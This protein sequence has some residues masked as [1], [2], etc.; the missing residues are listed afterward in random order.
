MTHQSKETQQFWNDTRISNYF[1]SKPAD[2]RLEKLLNEHVLTGTRALDLGCGGGRHSQFLVERGFRV[3][4][5]DVN[6]EMLRTTKAR[7]DALGKEIDIREGSIIDTTFDDT[8]FD[9]VVVTGVLHQARSADEYRVALTE[10]SRVL[11]PGGFVFLNIFTNAAW[12]PT[13]EVT[14]PPYVVRTKE[15][16]TMTLLPKEVFIAMMHDQG[17]ALDEEYGE[18][19]KQENTGPRAVYR[20]TFKKL[21]QQLP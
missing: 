13:Y 4:A 2:P 6:P 1:A 16:L 5:I 18:D 8:E 11:K 10:L 20:A 12:D 17:L 19:I 21:G 7:I 9:L 15:G 14:D 3:S